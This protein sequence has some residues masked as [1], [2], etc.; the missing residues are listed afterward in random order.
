V[1]TS[2]ETRVKQLEG[3][4]GGKCPEC[5]FDGDPSKIKTEVRWLDHTERRN[6]YCGTCGRATHIVVRWGEDWAS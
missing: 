5:G 4:V 2:L 3:G 6:E 1:A